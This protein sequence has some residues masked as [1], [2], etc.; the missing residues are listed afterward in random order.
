MHFDL[1]DGKTI[2]FGK[3]VTCDVSVPL[4]NDF[5]DDEQFKIMNFNGIVHLVDCSNSYPTRIQV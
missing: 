3:N 4:E 2:I 5:F 1:P